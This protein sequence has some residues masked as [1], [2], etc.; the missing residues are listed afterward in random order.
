MNDFTEEYIRNLPWT[1][2]TPDIHKT[3]VAGNIR[4][5]RLH[6]AKEIEE[7]KYARNFPGMQG[8]G[9]DAAIDDVKALLLP[10]DSNS[11]GK[12]NYVREPAPERDPLF[13]KAVELLRLPG[14]TKSITTNVLRL[15]LKTTYGRASA[16][17]DQLEAAGIISAPDEKTHRRHVV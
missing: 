8:G 10:P 11:L 6:V 3:L 12:D 7:L 4:A 16:L 17:I 5:F 9:Y 14:A 2:G 1:H 15:M 13:D